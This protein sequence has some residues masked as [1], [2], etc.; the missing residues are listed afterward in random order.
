MT[1]SLLLNRVKCF[2]PYTPRM[3]GQAC[4]FWGEHE[5]AKTHR[6]ADSSKKGSFSHAEVCKTAVQDGAE[7]RQVFFVALS[8]PV[9]ST[10]TPKLEPCALC[11]KSCAVAWSLELPFGVRRD[12]FLRKHLEMRKR[13]RD[14]EPV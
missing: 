7:P 3:L 2:Q 4:L 10:Q 5:A 6:E 1:Q 11:A 14:M 9:V 12:A 8:P 13:A